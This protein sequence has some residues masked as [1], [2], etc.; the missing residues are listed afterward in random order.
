MKLVVDTNR[1]IAALI[2]DSANRKVLFSGNFD[3][4]TPQETL[5][6][7]RKYKDYIIKKARIGEDGFE[8]LFDQIVLRVQIV[9]FEIMRP[10]LEEAERVMKSIDIK[11]KWFLAVGMALDRDGIWTD[12]KHFSLQNVLKPFT[13]KM[14]LDLIPEG[15]TEPI[16]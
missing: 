7:I 4:F 14:M 11:D 5:N 12:D 15:I 13:T 8:K 2:K 10:K 16:K 6:E 1:I 3:L 9:D